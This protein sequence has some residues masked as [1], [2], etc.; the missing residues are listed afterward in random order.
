L[1]VNPVA[2]NSLNLTA[3]VAIDSI[4]HASAGNPRTRTFRAGPTPDFWWV[5]AAYGI[6]FPQPDKM[7][8]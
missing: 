8:T 5:V 6:E 2:N 3:H 7:P 4:A 1:T